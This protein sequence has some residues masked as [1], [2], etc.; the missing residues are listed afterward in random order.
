MRQDEPSGVFAGGCGRMDGD[1]G[2]G[3]ERVA[4]AWGAGQGV[5][6]GGGVW[7]V[8]LTALMTV[9]LVQRQRVVAVGQEQCFSKM[10]FAV[11]RVEELPGFL[12]RDGSRLVR[13]SVQVSNRG[14][15]GMESEGRMR[16]YLVDAQGRRW[17]ESAG[18]SGVRLTARVAAGDSVVS[19][20]VFQVSGDATGLEL[21]LTHG[22]RQPGVLVI[23]DSDSWLH[24][25][26][27]VK[28]GR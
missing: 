23:G 24:R 17:E 19:E 2:A 3:G 28:L 16:A 13:V 9:S 8:Y 1:R 7:V 5:G 4:G 26:A 15:G 27:V 14:R 12:I 10:C 21:V 6:R 20:P 18:V 11:V 25:R 22:R